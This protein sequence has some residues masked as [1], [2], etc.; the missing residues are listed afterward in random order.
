M[1]SALVDAGP[2]IALFDRDDAHHVGIRELL[3]GTA[4]RLVT[5]WPAI[6]EAS[7]LLDFDV[8]AQVDLLRWV[9]G[10][11]V[12]VHETPVT[13][14]P[15]IIDLLETYR[16]LPMALADATLVAAAEDLGIR[17]I[18]TIDRDFAVYRTSDGGW[19]AN[20]YVPRS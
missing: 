9:Q 10:A 18:V 12:T 2:L 11:G 16:D 20:L 13:A 14:L 8:R 3:R 7:H 6:T 19:I 15:R 17:E 5:T 1:R 4:R